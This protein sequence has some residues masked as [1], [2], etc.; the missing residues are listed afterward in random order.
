FVGNLSV[1]FVRLGHQPSRSLDVSSSEVPLDGITETMFLALEILVLE[2][3]HSGFDQTKGAR[4]RSEKSVDTPANGPADY[5]CVLVERK[6]TTTQEVLE[7]AYLSGVE[8]DR[9]LYSFGIR[10]ICG[11]NQ[12]S[13]IET[14]V[15]HFGISSWA[16]R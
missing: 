9:Q 12:I 10:I 4:Q 13:G 11:D 6:T 16:R 14:C 3:V 2:N 15:R 1:F 7:H 5:L 8:L